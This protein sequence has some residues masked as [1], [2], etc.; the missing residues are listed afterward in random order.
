MCTGTLTFGIGT[1]DEP[2]PLAGIT[3]LVEHLVLRL[4]EPVTIIHNG[5]AGD[6]SLEFY[7][8]GTADEVSGHLNAVAG[9]IHRLA[10]VTEDELAFEKSVIEAE[11]PRPFHNV[12]SGLLTYRFGV[13]GVGTAQFGAPAT[14]G[15]SQPEIER[16]ALRWLTTENAALS[17]TGPVPASLDIS[18]PTGVR[19][20]REPPMPVV[21]TPR[22][23]ASSKEG[24]ALSVV[25]EPDLA[26]FLGDALRHELLWRL[27]HA[28]GLIYSVIVFTTWIDA[29][30]CQLDLVLDPI[31]DNV[32]ATLQ[33]SIRAIRE[34]AV[35]GFSEA[36]VQSARTTY[37][38]EIA[39]EASAV[40]D[41]LDQVAINGLLGREVSSREA[42]RDRA[43]SLTSEELTAALGASLPSLIAAFDDA[44]NLPARVTKALNLTVDDY[45][46]WEPYR[47]RKGR[48]KPG[49]NSYEKKW[50]SRISNTVFVL[51]N[52]HLVRRQNSGKRTGIAF[53]DVAV[54]GDRTCGCITIIDQRG[55]STNLDTRGWK[56]REKLRIKLLEAFAPHIVRAFPNEW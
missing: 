45:D 18:L 50:R 31:T 23:I 11:N 37:A 34:I 40:S 25:V 53:A 49:G 46:A 26:R 29:D 16:W 35:E 8:S 28:S 10:R 32:S 9:A 54:V 44:V 55:R 39:W 6:D 56:S 24:V 20:R 38:A 48:R 42:V 19:E 41:F 2:E 47:Q 14:S 15:F 27:R 36:S 51:T 52:T 17:F 7:A 12:S 5:H 22:L 13:S 21:S 43:A 33:A 30:G 1:R 4:I 3:H